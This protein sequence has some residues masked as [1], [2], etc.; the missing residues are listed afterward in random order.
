[1]TSS[2]RSLCGALLLGVGFF[3]SAAYAQPLVKS[4]VQVDAGST[5][6]TGATFGYRLTYNCSNTSGP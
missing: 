6:P 3:A 2:N 5:K 4:A 1:M